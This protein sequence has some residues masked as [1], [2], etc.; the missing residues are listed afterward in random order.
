V[1]LA[2]PEGMTAVP[3]PS[4]YTILFNEDG[5]A[6]I[7]ADCN[8]VGATYTTEG[9]NI[10]ITLGPST[11]AACSPESLDQVFLD[12]LINAAIYFF[13]EADLYMDLNADGG[14]MRFSATSGTAPIP[15]TDTEEGDAAPL[16]L[17]S[18]GP[19]GSEQAIIPGSQITAFF[20]DTE[21]S[22]FA[23]CN[24][25]S[26]ALTTVD[27]YFT[28]GPIAT[29]QKLCS[30]PAGIME[31]E[32]AYLAALGGTS[33]YQWEEQL[34]NDAILVTAGQVYYVLTDGT[35]GVLNFITTP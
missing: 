3:A 26:A 35:S 23:G 28:V 4:S 8:Q 32:S 24:D 21:V 29:T 13:E 22:G 17:V 1:S 19:I 2:D 25:Y 27:D 14:T 10:S 33:G 6:N 34:V 9:S 31:Q 5:T 16:N 20:S 11:L 7:K 15:P 12:G 18:F 30:E